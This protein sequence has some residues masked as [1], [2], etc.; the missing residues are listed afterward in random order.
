L[1][2]CGIAARVAGLLGTVPFAEFIDAT[3]LIEQYVFARVEGVRLRAY[4]DLHEGVGSTLKFNRVFGLYRRTGNEFVVARQ[5][6]KN[7]LAVFGMN[8]LFHMQLLDY[9]PGFGFRPKRDAKVRAFGLI[10]KPF[11]WAFAYL[12]IT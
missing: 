9:L 7:D 5:V 10:H 1:L 12:A 2:L 6:V 11:W 3:S 8:A 4:L